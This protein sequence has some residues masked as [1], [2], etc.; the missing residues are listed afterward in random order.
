MSEILARQLKAAREKLGLSQS[1]AAKEWGI[2]VRTLQNWEHNHQT[3]R[4]LAL[5]AI[6]SL[7]DGILNEPKKRDKKPP[8][9]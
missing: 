2:P 6:N 4:G 5:T 7:L 3:P 8:A 1:Q 9:K